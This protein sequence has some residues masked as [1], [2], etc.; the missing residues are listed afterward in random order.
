MAG[1]FNLPSVENMKADIEKYRNFRLRYNYIELYLS[2]YELSKLMNIFLFVSL[3]KSN[4][5]HSY[6]HGT[7]VEWIPYLDELAVMIGAKP[8]FLK[9]MFKD[10]K[11]FINCYFG[12]S[13][14]YQYRL[15]GPHKWSAAKHT[16][17]TTNERIDAPFVSTRNTIH[18]QFKDNVSILKPY[19]EYNILIRLFIGLFGVFFFELLTSL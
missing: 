1:N 4:F 16:I 7:Q 5:T 6:R 11:L 3:K 10:P 18:H 9:M 8:N 19:R 15:E 2:T 12:P 14:P 13:L 17:Y